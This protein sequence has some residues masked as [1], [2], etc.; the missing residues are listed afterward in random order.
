MNL[1]RTHIRKSIAL[2][3]SL[4]ACTLGQPAYSKNM[5]T[6]KHKMPAPMASNFTIKRV[7]TNKAVDWIKVDKDGKFELG[8]Q[9]F[10]FTPNSI[11]DQ[12][13]KV[14]VELLPSGSILL[15]GNPTG[16]SIDQAGN[17]CSKGGKLTWKND[18]LML[19]KQGITVSPASQATRSS[20]ALIL[21]AFA[22]GQ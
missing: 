12:Q 11:T 1:L 16:G 22:I 4:M 14:L 20:A 3:F 15:N 10:K 21:F 13:G 5:Q 19:N 17:L 2:S 7:M 6:D 18:I 8:G 9:L